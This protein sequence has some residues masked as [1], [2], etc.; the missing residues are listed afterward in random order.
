MLECWGDERVKINF[1]KRFGFVIIRGNM[2][3]DIIIKKSKINGKGVFATKD[4]KKG[5]II[6]KWKPR[7]LNAEELKLL[8][9]KEKT[10][11]IQIDGDVFFAT[12]SRKICK[13]IL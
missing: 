2:R 12:T 1:I 11:T 8:S 6:L 7:L 10:Y 9:K 13:Q 5:E 3:K 4:F